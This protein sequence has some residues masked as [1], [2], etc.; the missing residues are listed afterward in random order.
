MRGL[1]VCMFFVLEMP[2]ESPPEQA[3]TGTLARARIG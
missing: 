2:G 1:V 3:D